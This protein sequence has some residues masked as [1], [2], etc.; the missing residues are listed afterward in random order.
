VG[1][2]ANKTLLATLLAWL[3]TRA[4]RRL[5]GV[6][7]LIGAVTIA[8]RHGIDAGRGGRVVQ[9]EARALGRAAEQL[10]D[11]R[12]GDSLT[13]AERRLRAL[14]GIVRCDPHPAQQTPRGTSR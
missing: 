2:L 12:A 4:L 3:L 8:G 11:D 7:V 1:E 5:A 9:C 14:R 6:A 13:A 10:R